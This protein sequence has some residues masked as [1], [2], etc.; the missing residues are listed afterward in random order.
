MESSS[1][2]LALWKLICCGFNVVVL[3]LPDIGKVGPAG[4]AA[5]L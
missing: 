3:I 5:S 4:S 2:S 1:R